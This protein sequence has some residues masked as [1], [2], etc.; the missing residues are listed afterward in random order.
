MAI[1]RRHFIRAG[2]VTVAAASAT[3]SLNVLAAERGVQSDD[4][5]QS[6]GSSALLNKAMF[7]AHLNT[8]FLIAAQN[9]QP[10][11]AKLVDLKDYEPEARGAG[12]CFTLIFSAPPHRGLKQNTYRIE[13]RA[14]GQF[15]LFIAPVRSVK[16][17]QLYE[18][19]INHS[20]A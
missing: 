14:L 2:A 13:H 4:A 8:A 12:E 18:A 11:R 15:D 10:V 3:A 9:A 19:I 16:H 1:S 17:G 7:V 5:L 6:G 20:R